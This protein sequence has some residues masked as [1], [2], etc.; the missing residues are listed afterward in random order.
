MSDMEEHGR[1]SVAERIIRARGETPTHGRPEGAND[2]QRYQAFVMTEGFPQMGFSVF[3]TNGQRHGFFY[4]NIDSLD[5]AEGKH[6]QYVKLTHRGKAMTMRGR[7][8]HELFQAIMDHTLQAA[9]EFSEALYP[10]T[11]ENAP[12]IERVRVDDM[13]PSGKAAG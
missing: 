7:G 5:L 9:Y 11:D 4:H 6:G 8:L 10:A 1:R 2:A 12:V 13:G 3:C